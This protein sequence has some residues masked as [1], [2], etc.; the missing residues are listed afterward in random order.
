MI[1]QKLQ[2]RYKNNSFLSLQ[3]L[4]NQRISLYHINFLSL[5]YD[6]K[7]RNMFMFSRA[8]ADYRK[9]QAFSGN[10]NEISVSI[11]SK[12]IP[13]KQHPHIEKKK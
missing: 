2:S 7:L 9:A 8:E 12:S 13:E 3:V 10:G 6:V 11:R 4:S 1:Q 5:A